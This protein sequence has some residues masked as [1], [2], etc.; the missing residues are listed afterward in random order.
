MHNRSQYA[1]A[2][3]AEQKSAAMALQS[4]RSHPQSGR[5]YRRIHLTVPVTLLNPGESRVAEHGV[6]E[7]VSPRGARVLV[8]TPIEPNVL[9]LLRSPTPRFRTSVRVV[10]CERIS[11]GQFGLGLELE[12]PSVN[13]SGDPMDAA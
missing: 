6:T 2:P 7:N 13:W 4:A 1:L 12:G 9:L 11:G 3:L 10:Y 5:L 8:T